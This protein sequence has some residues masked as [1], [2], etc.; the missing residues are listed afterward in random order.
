MSNSSLVNYTKISPNSNN[1]RKYPITKITIHHAAGVA[2]VEGLGSVFAK[3]STGASAN[4]GIGADGRVGLYV[5]EANSAWTSSN[6]D[7]DERAITIEVAN[8][9]KGGN[10]PVSDKVLAKLIDL[11]VDICQRNGIE[12]LN[13][14]GDKTGNLTRHNMFAATTCPGPYL[15][16]RFPYIAQEVNKRLRAAQA[17]AE[18]EKTQPTQTTTAGPWRVQIGAFS[19]QDSAERRR[20]NAIAAGLT[21]TN[22]Y[23]V[24][25]KLYRV[26]VGGFATKPEAEQLLAKVKA[27][28][29][30]GIVTKL[31]GTSITSTAS[32]EPEKP[33][34]P[35]VGD[36]VNFTGSKQYTSANGWLARGAKPGQAKIT[37]IY[38]LGKSKHPYHLKRTG[39]TGPYG[40][41]DAGTF[42]KA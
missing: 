29:F 2:S 35:A 7:N 8:S 4:Y 15:Q 13:Y 14:T 36:V 42:S 23:E 3:T 28:G 11:C 12:A 30:S 24:D 18:P 19:S 22:I 41:V 37:R 38:K 26:Q 39:K 21:D 33:W 40:W 1:P 32:K 17:P 16:E 31:S 9:A 34:V 5:D 20:A 25:G 6:R 27:A 10:W